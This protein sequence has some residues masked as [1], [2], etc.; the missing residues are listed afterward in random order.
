MTKIPVYCE[1]CKSQIAGA[2]IDDLKEPMVG[3]MFDSALAHLGVSS[4]FHPQVRWEFMKC[5][6]CGY[7]PFLRRDRVSITPSGDDFYIFGEPYHKPEAKKTLYE[8]NQEAIDEEEL[9]LESE[10]PEPEPKPEPEPE[11][12]PVQGL[13]CRYCEKP[14]KMEAFLIKHEKV[15]NGNPANN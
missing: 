7:R 10:Q 4:P 13:H 11:P 3:A 6:Y 5:P 14:Y 8:R 9:K 2:D 1:I 12:K 15:C